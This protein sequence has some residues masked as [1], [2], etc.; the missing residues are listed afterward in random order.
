MTL[1]GFGLT[2]FDKLLGCATGLKGVVCALGLNWLVE[3]GFRDYY[4]DSPLKC[5]RV[6]I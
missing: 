6:C 2:L 4:W 3:I 5:N 1:T